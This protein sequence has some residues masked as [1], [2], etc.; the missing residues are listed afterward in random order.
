MAVTKRLRHEVFRRD[1][2]TCQTCGRRAPEVEITIDHVIPVALGGSDDPSNLVTA[3]RDCN[4]GKSSSSPDAPVVAG[5]AKDARRWSEAMTVAAAELL[6]RASG[7]VDAHEHFAK[8]WARYGTGPRRTPLPKDPGWQHTV[9][10]LLGAGLP[11]GILKECIEIAMSRRHV[12]EDK[13]FRYMCGVAWRKITELQSRARDIVSTDCGEQEMSA[14]ELDAR[15][16]M[17]CELLG[18]L[19]ERERDIALDEM[20]SVLGED[21]PE[22]EACTA[23]GE[24][25]GAVMERRQMTVALRYLLDQHPNGVRFLDEAYEHLEKTS[26]CFM[27]KDL[28]RVAALKLME[29]YKSAGV[30]T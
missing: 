22:I 4:S 7:Q 30:A 26:G 24:F 5:V 15:Q 21:D 12:A 13:V 14:A 8:A 6:A 19:T 2:K 23:F 18:S 3:C 20:R 17:A 11:M 10:Q 27:E 28:V 29:A 1:D 9:D 25:H 16:R